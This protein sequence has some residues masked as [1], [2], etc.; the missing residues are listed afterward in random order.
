MAM[1]SAPRTA[2]GSAGDLDPS[3]PV[4]SSGGLTPYQALILY[5]EATGTDAWPRREGV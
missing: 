1:A 3:T 5:Q 4:A 2:C